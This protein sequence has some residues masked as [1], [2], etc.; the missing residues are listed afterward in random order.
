[1][2]RGCTRL[3]SPFCTRYASLPA[4]FH[5]PIGVGVELKPHH[6]V[7]S[8]SLSRRPSS[9]SPTFTPLVSLPLLPGLYTVQRLFQGPSSMPV[10]LPIKIS[11]T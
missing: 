5:R 2:G 4:G 8:S 6:G 1:M 10:P 3:R 7:S 11:D 9:V